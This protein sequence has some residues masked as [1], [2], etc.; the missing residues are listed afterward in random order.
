[1]VDVNEGS[2][3]PTMHIN[4]LATTALQQAQFSGPLPPNQFPGQYSSEGSGA[5]SSQLSLGGDTY[6][7]SKESN[8][9]SISSIGARF[10]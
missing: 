8:A 10:T 3:D 1:M 5:G 7:L 6:T 9:E 2:N 4:L